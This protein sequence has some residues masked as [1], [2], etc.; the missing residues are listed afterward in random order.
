MWSRD[1][2]P[3]L[4]PA[5]PAQDMLLRADDYLHYLPQKTPQVQGLLAI[6][7]SKTSLGCSGVVPLHTLSSVI[8]KAGFLSHF[9]KSLLPRGS[10]HFPPTNL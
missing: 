3:L 1:L 7:S 2:E 4:Q 5:S 9:L 8:L 6:R 10:G